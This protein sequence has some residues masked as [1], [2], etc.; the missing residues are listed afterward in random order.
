MV[1]LVLKYSQCK[2]ETSMHVVIHNDDLRINFF[3]SFFHN[4]YFCKSTGSSHLH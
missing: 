4:F 2:V 3:L 1:F